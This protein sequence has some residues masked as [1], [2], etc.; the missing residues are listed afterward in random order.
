M[1]KCPKG[2]ELY[3]FLDKRIGKYRNGWKGWSLKD[4]EESDKFFQIVLE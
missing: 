4:E 2:K 3:E 1:E